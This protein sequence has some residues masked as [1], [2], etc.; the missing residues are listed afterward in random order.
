MK[1]YVLGIFAAAF[2]VGMTAMAGCNSADNNNVSFDE[3]SKAGV[4]EIEISPENST[5][6]PE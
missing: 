5:A 2:L 4:Q 3:E 1:K 6:E